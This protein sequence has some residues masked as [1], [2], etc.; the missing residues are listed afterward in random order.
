M[1]TVSQQSDHVTKVK[2]ISTAL[3][4]LATRANGLQD[5]WNYLDLSN[6][7]DEENCQGHTVAEIAAFYTTLTALQALLAAGHGTN[8][9]KLRRYTA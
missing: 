1:A 6:E 7:L 4:D 3:L 2:D 5:D 8:L 9:A